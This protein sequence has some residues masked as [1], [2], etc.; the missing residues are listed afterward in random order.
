MTSTLSVSKIQGL[1][2]AA[3][4]TTVEIASGHKITGSAGSISVP[5]TILQAKHTFN[6]PGTTN[7]TITSTSFVALGVSLSITPTSTSNKI[8]AIFSCPMYATGS[9][10]HILTL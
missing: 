5:G 4:P 8:L 7:V 9:D 10:H 3:S 1:A 6:P 2:T